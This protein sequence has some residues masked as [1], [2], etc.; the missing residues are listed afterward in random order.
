MLEELEDDPDQTSLLCLGLL[1]YAEAKAAFD[2][3]NPGVIEAWKNSDL[4]RRV[5]ETD[6]ELAMKFA[7]QQE[8]EANSN[9]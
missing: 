6:M 3:D 9:G 8:E 7:A 5:Q 1:K 4:M 2:T